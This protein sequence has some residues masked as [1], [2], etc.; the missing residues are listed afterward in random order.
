MRQHPLF[1]LESLDRRIAKRAKFRGTSGTFLKSRNPKL[2]VIR[3]LLH[4]SLGV[5]ASDRSLLFNKKT[6]RCMK[7]SMRCDESSEGD[8]ILFFFLVH[9]LTCYGARQRP[10]LKK[11]LKQSAYRTLIFATPTFSRL[12]TIAQERCVFERV[13]STPLPTSRDLWRDA[14][15][16][17]WPK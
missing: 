1:F 16:V 4:V 15:V 9:V 10:C 8:V 13:M 12:V 5:F 14:L 6:C 2:V 11:V 3:I 7:K 17:D